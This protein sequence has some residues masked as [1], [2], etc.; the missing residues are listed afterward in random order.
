MR[1]ERFVVKKPSVKHFENSTLPELF[2]LYLGRTAL[3]CM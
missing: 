2:P 1:N 3:S